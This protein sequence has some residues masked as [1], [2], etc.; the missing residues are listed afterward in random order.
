MLRGLSH[1]GS[2]D[3]MVYMEEKGVFVYSMFIIIL[4]FH[5]GNVE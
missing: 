3:V 1:K 2:V 4:T 5:S